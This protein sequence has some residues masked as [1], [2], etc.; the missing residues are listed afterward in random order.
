MNKKCLAA[1]VSAVLVTMSGY[2]FSA[3]GQAIELDPNKGFVEL[4]SDNV[5]K[6]VAFRAGFR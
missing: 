5:G 1:L 3:T 4:L 2:A 6:R